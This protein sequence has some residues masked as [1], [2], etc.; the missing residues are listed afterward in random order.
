MTG[1]PEAAGP[2]TTLGGSW[3]GLKILFIDSFH[4]YPRNDTMHQGLLLDVSKPG[5]FPVLR[6]LHSSEGRQPVNK[7]V[8]RGDERYEEQTTAK[9]KSFFIGSSGKASLIR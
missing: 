6:G 8:W 4:K 3:Y 2:E 9:E 7:A 5:K 1:A